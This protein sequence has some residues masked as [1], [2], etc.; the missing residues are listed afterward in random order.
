MA[1]TGTRRSKMRRYESLETA[2]MMAGL[3]GLKDVLY[4]QL[5]M[6]RVSREWFLVGDHWCEGGEQWLG[7]HGL[8]STGKGTN[9]RS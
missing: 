9:A 1:E 4:V 2:E 6:G 8:V 5:P 3:E 7:Y